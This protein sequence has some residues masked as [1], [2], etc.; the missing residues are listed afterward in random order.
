MI[1]AIVHSISA[2][3][4][5]GAGDVT[6]A[7]LE[8]A[9]SLAPTLVAA[10]GGAELALGFGRS[11]DAVIGEFDSLDPAVRASLP[12]DKLHHVAEQDSTDFEKTLS[13]TNAPAVIGVGFLGKRLDHQLAALHTLFTY[14]HRLCVLI[15]ET[16]LA[17]LAPP[18]IRL[19]TREGE[20]VSLFPL[21]AVTGQSAGLVWPIEGLNFAPGR[22]S[23]TSN[24]A[25]GPVT[26]TMN[27][28]GMV[29]ILPKRLLG[30]VIAQ[31]GAPDFVN[32]SARNR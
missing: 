9:L 25:T 16:E 29:L 19:A 31:G 28:P 3:T 6:A 21:G 12:Q 4:L 15:G 22:Q 1:E 20:N 14:Q 18:S 27:D 10:D 23:G 8:L 7:D 13:R 17:L 26:L 24:R 30:E 2:V 32:W 11:P 5:I